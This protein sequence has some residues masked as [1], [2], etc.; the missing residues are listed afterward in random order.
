LQSVTP[1]GDSITSLTDNPTP[2]ATLPLPAAANVRIL[3]G[4]PELV[5]DY[6]TDTCRRAEGYDLPD[7]PARAFRTPDG[8]IELIF[9]GPPYNFFQ[10]GA[11][12]ASLQHDC[13]TPALITTDSPDAFTFDNQEWILAVYRD[14]DLVHALIHNEYHDPRA[15]NCLPGVTTPENH[16]WYNTITYAVSTDGGY[17]FS[18]P[19]APGQLAAALPIP[20]NPNAIEGRMRLP[21]PYGYMSPS[22]IVQGTDG[23]FYSLFRSLPDP[24]GQQGGGTCLMRTAALTDPSSW[25]AWDGSGFNLTMFSPYDLNGNP[26]P[27]GLS[28]CT[29]VSPEN[30]LQMSD[31]L[32]FNTYLNQ[33]ILVG[34]AVAPVNGALTCGTFFTLSSDLVHWS[35]PQLLMEHQLPFP[36]CIEADALPNGSIMYPSLIDHADES[37]NFEFTSQSAYLY[38]VLWNDGLD[39]DLWRIPVTFSFEP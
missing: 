5:F 20:W 16:C 32:T 30:T 17:T 35:A 2:S 37:L 8:S 4:A 34:A 15:A 38:Y 3:L 39:R 25:R 7:V 1:T 10:R 28:A 18:Q 29:Y 19:G 14:G 27:T 36:P 23:Y 24:L 22:N 9:T 6:S 21:N 33:Y 11:G 31:S 13:Q 12:F 26:A